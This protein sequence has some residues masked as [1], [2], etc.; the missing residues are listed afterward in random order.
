MKKKL[1]LC[2]CVVLLLVTSCGKVP[3]LENGKDAVV[4]SSDGEISVDDLYEEMKNTYALTTLINMIDTKILE[5]DYPSGDE[6]KEYIKAQLEQLEYTYKN[7]YYVN[8]YSSFN[9]FAV[10]Y[11]GVSDMDAVNKALALQ[12]KKEAYLDDYAKSL[13]TDK[14]IESYYNDKVIGDIKASHILI[15]ADYD[16]NATDEEKNKAYEEAL[17]KANEVLT[18]LKNGKKFEDLAK[19]YSQDGTKDDGGDLG[20]FNRGDM[21]SEFEEAA[22]KLEKGKY[23]KEPVKTKF[24]Y[25]IILKTDQK[26]KPALKDVKEDVIDTLEEEKKSADSSLQNKALINL[27]KEKK[28]EIEDDT[29]KKQYKNYIESISN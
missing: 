21:V 6:E 9:A 13:V 24:G 26:E 2:M 14:E 18:K 7:S 11:F 1:L 28:V 5:K 20:W 4:T 15:K 23:T 27:R 16:D 12:Y 19:E 25:H 8:Y 17:K 10:A 29:L 22:I 3:K